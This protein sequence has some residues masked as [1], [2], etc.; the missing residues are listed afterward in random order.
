MFSVWLLCFVVFSTVG[1]NT[2][3]AYSAT[4]QSGP[5]LGTARN[6]FAGSVI[7][8]KIYV[9]GGNG[10]PDGTNLK[11]TEM[12]DPETGSWEYQADNEHNDGF[13]VEEVSGASVNGKFYVFGAYG[14]GDPYGDFNFVEE[15]DPATDEWTSKA[16]MP[17]TKASATAVA[18]NNK[19]YVFG[20][21]LTNVVEAYDPG[22][23]SWETVTH[24]PQTL[25]SP[26][27]A[28]VADQAYVI[29]GASVVD[30]EPTA[31]VSDVSVYD[32]VT[33]VWTT[34]GLA[35][36]PRSRAFSYNSAAPVVD[37]KIYLIGGIEAKTSK[38]YRSSD[39]VDIYDTVSNTWQTGVPLPT[40]TSSH[41]SV[42]A[43]NVIYVVGGDNSA[44]NSSK[45]IT[46]AVWKYDF[47]QL[48]F[49]S[50]PQAE[51]GVLYDAPFV[52]GGKPPYTVDII[53]GALPAGLAIDSGSIIGTPAKAGN[54]NVTVKV[55]DN[56]GSS[57]SIK[58]KLTVLKA[59][60]I[61]T[62][63][64]KTGKVGK[65]YK[66]SLKAA[67]GKA[68]FSWSLSSG[69]LP[70]GVDLDATKGLISGEPT[71]S[72]SYDLTFQVTDTLGGVASKSFVLV[73]K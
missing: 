31:L 73:I 41:L 2:P 30:G 13:G 63:S 45:G 71:T 8:D 9:F 18:Y 37:G 7:D 20:N 6:Q 55:T 46:A 59:L 4:W 24:M 15:Y 27:V 32:F 52:A 66:T 38:S 29:G 1:F 62:K 28:V 69:T 42:L 16:P 72:G 11:S 51:M 54:S 67:G 61:N 58:F 65:T 56:L 48:A 23:N 21:A 70:E 25:V 43:N 19:I 49:V 34:S 5:A 60:T 17:T 35:P 64:L 39:K 68:P 3:S 47:N 22:T 14:G 44:G 12:F 40:P 50:I 26:A 36:L 53:K 33:G 10:N 57:I